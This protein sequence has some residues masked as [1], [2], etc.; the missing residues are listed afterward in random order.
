M[1]L[2]AR[3]LQYA[4]AFLTVETP[5]SELGRWI[6]GASTGIQ[7]HDMTSVSNLAY[8]TQDGSFDGT[9]Y[10]DSVALRTGT[11]PPDVMVEATVHT[12]NQN[13]TALC[14]VELWVRSAMSANSITG[15]ETN[16][17]V[18]HDGSQYIGVVRWN[19]PLNSFTQYGTNDT[20]PGLV[21]GDQI[22]VRVIGNIHTVYVN[23]VLITTH[24]LSSLGGFNPTTGNPGMG[25]WWHNNGAVGVAASD[26]GLRR[27]SARP[28]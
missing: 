6:N 16:F 1:F 2:V 8:G 5:V 15:V 25:H 14:E 12:A 10:R 17:R 21:D 13:S 20:G 3:D 4:T 27:W 18:T 23:G 9:N 19:G 11:W 7:W 26:Y 24:D 22:A 28:I